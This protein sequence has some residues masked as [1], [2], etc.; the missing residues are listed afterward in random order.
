V[1]RRGLVVTSEVNM[2]LISM[3]FV[4]ADQKLQRQPLRTNTARRVSLA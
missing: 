3:S 2:L 1:D 4:P